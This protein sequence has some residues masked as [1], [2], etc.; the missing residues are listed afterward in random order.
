MPRALLA[1]ARSRARRSLT[2]RAR[3]R[4]LLSPAS[5]LHGYSAHWSLH[6]DVRGRSGVCVLLRPGLVLRSVRFSLDAGEAARGEHHPEGRVMVLEFDTLRVLFTY[7]P[8]NGST[9]ASFLRRA[10]FDAQLRDFMA[11]PHDKPLVWCAPTASC[12]AALL[13]G[14]T[15]ATMLVRSGAAT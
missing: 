4:R 5:P 15:R 13:R 3:A 11:A 8:N 7:S 12:G 14:V 9:P 6:R 1:A 2:R 10:A